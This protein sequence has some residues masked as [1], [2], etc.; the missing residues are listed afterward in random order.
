MP[1]AC[2]I[3]SP[4]HRASNT[5]MGDQAKRRA[6]QY[7]ERAEEVRLKAESARDAVAQRT[8]LEL[9]ITYERLAALTEKNIIIPGPDDL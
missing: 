2:G 5:A 6:K 1:S 8:L 7:R 3:A 9:A 4:C